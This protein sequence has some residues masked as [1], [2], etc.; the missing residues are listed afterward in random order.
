LYIDASGA[1]ERY[2]CNMT[3]D[4]TGGLKEANAGSGGAGAPPNSDTANRAPDLTKLYP[5]NSITVEWYASRCIHS[6]NC[7]RGLP[8]VFDPRT[9]PW[10]HG[11]ND[12]AD[13]IAEVIERC[14]SGALRYR[15]DD[16]GPAEVPDVPVTLTPI[17]NGPLYVRG[18]VV[19]RA[20]DGTD[21]RRDYRMS[22]CRC[23]HSERFPFCD[24]TCRKT[25]WTEP[26]RDSLEGPT[27]GPE[28]APPSDDGND[29]TT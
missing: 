7:V 5:G 24:N 17:R 8:N 20:L 10:V 29:R 19:A 14:P 16:G 27:G 6:A 22:L 4:E 21:L 1:V 18:D 3:E 11:E 26:R 2:D 13:R 23:D 15:R 12:T 9:R 28:S 25:G